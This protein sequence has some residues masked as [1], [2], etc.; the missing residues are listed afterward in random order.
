MS[1][2]PARVVR[3]H[4]IGDANVLKIE[5]IDFPAPAA[6]EIRIK[7][8]S[9]GLNRAEIMYRIGQYL[10][11][12]VFP[13]GLGYESSGTIESLGA[14]AAS[15]NPDLK[16]GDAVSVV[17]PPDMSKWPSYGELSN[18]P[19]HLVVKNPENFT[20]QEAAASWMQYVTAY[21]GL[22]EE[23]Q[24]ESGDFLIVSAASSSVGIAAFQIARKVGATVIAT[25]RKSDKRA[26]LLEAGAHHVIATEEEDFVSRVK[27]ITGGVG[28][29]VAFDPV[30]GP[31]VA[32]LLEAL[33][34]GGILVEYGA[35]ST[36]QGPF[37]QLTILGKSLTIK[38]YLYYE[39]VLG[40]KGALERA[41]KF[42]LDGFKT[43]ALKPLISR[44]FAFEQ[45]V[46]ATQYLE[47][48]EQI[49]KVIVNL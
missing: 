31:F 33:A 41:K 5:K 1:S 44:E 6:D 20:F 7:V 35:L 47:S 13:S 8:K 21:G 25:T 45:I 49:G 40:R 12:P 30:G 4:A 18:V 34:V 28:A 2:T 46:E 32:T 42:I 48:N 38:G 24:L 36:E 37:P 29:R 39:G 17:P 26:A 19:T 14:D 43:G 11:Q 3:F 15:I 10:T 16:I 22:I 9:I 23:A 27:E